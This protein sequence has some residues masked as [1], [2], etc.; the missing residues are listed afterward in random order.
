MQFKKLSNDTILKLVF[1]DEKIMIWFL[2]RILKKNIKSINIF[3]GQDGKPITE[4]SIIKL[5]KQ[6]LEKESI[7]VKSKIVDLL[8]KIGNEI[9]NIEYNNT[10]NEDVKKRNFAYISNVY[11]NSLK[12]KQDYINQPVCTQ[13]NLC[14]NIS[15]GFNNEINYV[16]G[17]KYNNKFIN[18]INIY[19]FNIAEYKKILYTGNKKLIKEN[20]HLIM[21]DCN[22]E[23]LSMLE[24][25]DDMM[26]KIHKLVKKYNDDSTIYQFLTTEEDQEKMTRTRIIR[27]EQQGINQGIQQGIEQNKIKTAYSLLKE[28]VP[29]DIISRT[30]G[31]TQEYLKSIKI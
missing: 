23:E 29:L 11:S 3:N 27:A 25:F 31:Y 5:I 6:E 9:Y 22:D 20:L 19:E 30:T 10:Y 28:N 18:N 17:E 16:K 21:F 15:D 4:D 14:S 7:N 1:S 8:V 26:K 12:K 24:E 2:E 13:I